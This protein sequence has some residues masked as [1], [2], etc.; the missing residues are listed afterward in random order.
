ML[1]LF[2]RGLDARTSAYALPSTSS[3]GDVKS[4]IEERQGLPSCCQGLVFAGR[5][6]VDTSALSDVVQHHS[7]LHLVLRLRGGKGGFGNLLRGQGRDG[8]ITDNFDACRDLQGR[9]IRVSTNE[10]KLVAWKAQEAERELEKVASK[11]ERETARA[12]KK[13][14]EEESNMEGVKEA[15]QAAVSSVQAAVADALAASA[16]GTSAS[17]SGSGPGT[18]ALSGSGADL[19]RRAGQA[20]AAA[21]VASKTV[22]KSRMMMA[23]ECSSGSDDSSDEEAEEAVRK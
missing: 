16:A 11:H 1:Q 6:L 18:G 19:K 4:L 23:L 3:V 5:Q 21:A 22:K 7:T 9:R 8:K 13:E 20:A 2:V 10:A 15:Q 14:A 12:A 17:G